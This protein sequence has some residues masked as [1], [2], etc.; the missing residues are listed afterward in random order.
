MLYLAK[1]NSIFKIEFFYLFQVFFR[2]FV[3]LFIRV[4]ATLIRMSRMLGFYYKCSQQLLC[5]NTQFC[6]RFFSSPA[7]CLFHLDFLLYSLWAYIS[8]SWIHNTVIFHRVQGDGVKLTFPHCKRCRYTQMY[9]ISIMGE[10]Y[11][12]DYIYTQ[13]Y[14]PWGSSV[15][16]LLYFHFHFHFES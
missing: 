3:C 5:H 14:Q 2:L 6:S 9:G 11:S 15:S 8:S 4:V 16:L 1:K 13:R 12:L 10:N 7:L